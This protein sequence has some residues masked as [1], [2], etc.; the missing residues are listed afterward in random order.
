MIS[1]YSIEDLLS[2]NSQGDWYWV[3]LKL[4][5]ARA[6]TISD[7]ADLFGPGMDRV[8][9]PGPAET[10][11]FYLDAF[12][13]GK[14]MSWQ[15]FCAFL[16]DMLAMM[17]AR[18]LTGCWWFFQKL[19]LRYCL[20]YPGCNRVALLILLDLNLT[21]WFWIVCFALFEQVSRVAT[22]MIIL[23]V[24]RLPRNARHWTPFVWDS[25][26]WKSREMSGSYL[27][28]VLGWFEKFHLM[29]PFF[30][31]R[32]GIPPS[33]WVGVGGRWQ[34]AG[35]L[36]LYNMCVVCSNIYIYICELMHVCDMCKHVYV[37][38]NTHANIELCS[39]LM[40]SCLLLL[41]GLAGYT[42]V[43]NMLEQ[44][45]LISFKEL[46]WRII[47]ISLPPKRW[48]GASLLEIGPPKRISV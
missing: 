43:F 37:D 38:A 32:H 47:A 28:L 48:Y 36:S 39:S 46:S 16:T 4:A 24:V 2:W 25:W 15:E 22:L 41:L 6:A 9:F 29:Y 1:C 42:Q 14:L 23:G 13:G 11:D 19:V 31:R 35:C 20:F 44:G 33:L 27:K 26:C 5:E 8:P 3:K 18:D 7:F 30:V 45:R 17:G 40:Q 34:V 10:Q 21:W 12:D